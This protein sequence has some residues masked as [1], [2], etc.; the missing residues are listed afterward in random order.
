MKIIMNL[1]YCP[2]FLYDYIY[3]LLL[4][5]QKD[6]KVGGEFWLSTMFEELITWQEKVFYNLSNFS[7]NKFQFLHSQNLIIQKQWK[8]IPRL[9]YL[10][11]ILHASSH[12]P[13]LPLIHNSENSSFTIL[14]YS[15][16]KLKITIDLATNESQQA[17][18]G[19]FLS[20]LRNLI[21]SFS[22]RRKPCYF[23]NFSSPFPRPLV[24]EKFRPLGSR[25]FD[26]VERMVRGGARTRLTRK[27]EK[28]RESEG[29]IDGKRGERDEKRGERG[30]GGMVGVGW[31]LSLIV[32]RV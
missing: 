10:L 18:G 23:E 16:T 12:L 15:I 31:G 30:R 1:E 27:K 4:K 3:I 29:E 22:A 11:N 28:E 13:H 6:N 24:D 21:G 19:T 7:K 8:I 17:V 2:L 9:N 5:L 25:G 20:S 32:K 26:I 14:S